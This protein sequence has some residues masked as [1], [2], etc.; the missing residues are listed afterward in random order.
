MFMNDAI[1]LCREMETYHFW[2]IFEADLADP[3]TWK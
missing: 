2:L 3:S 1:D